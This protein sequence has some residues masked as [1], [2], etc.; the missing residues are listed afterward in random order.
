MVIAE[1]SKHGAVASRGGVAM[2]RLGVITNEVRKG[3]GELSMNLLLPCLMFS[4]VR[5]WGAKILCLGVVLR[6][7][8]GQVPMCWAVFPEKGCYSAALQVIHCDHAKLKT[9]LPCPEMSQAP[10]I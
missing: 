1:I 5:V 8:E 9:D 6:V 7:F 2:T 4:Q 3:L 10:C